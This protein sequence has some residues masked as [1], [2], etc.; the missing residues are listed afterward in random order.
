MDNLRAILKVQL[1]GMGVSYLLL[2]DLEF[3]KIDQ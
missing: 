3:F 2:P 1:P